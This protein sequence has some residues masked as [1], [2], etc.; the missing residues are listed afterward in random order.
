VWDFTDQLQAGENTGD[1]AAWVC[2]V[3]AAV[4]FTTVSASYT[5]Y[6]KHPITGISQD[7]D[8][9]EAMTVWGG[10]PAGHAGY[11]S[12]GT[13]TAIVHGGGDMGGNVAQDT[14]RTVTFAAGTVA[15]TN[16]VRFGFSQSASHENFRIT[17]VDIQISGTY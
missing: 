9:T 11:F 12:F 14:S 1:N 15:A 17:N 5:I 10:Q 3:Y 4:D 6:G 16:T 2:D 8:D 13:P 7:P